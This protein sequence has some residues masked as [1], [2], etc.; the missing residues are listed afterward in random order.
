MEAFFIV[1]DTNLA[2]A[3]DS[4]NGTG[5]GDQHGHRQLVRSGYS[6]AGEWQWALGSIA[7]PAIDFGPDLEF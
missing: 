4:L 6:D 7:N 3:H 2:V 5:R 1:D